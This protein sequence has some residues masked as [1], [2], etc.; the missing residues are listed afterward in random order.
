MCGLS[1]GEG[2]SEAALGFLERSCL[3]QRLLMAHSCAARCRWGCLGSPAMQHAQLAQMVGRP[4]GVVVYRSCSCGYR[5]RPEAQGHVD[6]IG[7]PVWDE[8]MRRHLE[9]CGVLLR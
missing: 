4:G 6:F 8:R 2:G 5:P 9:R 3:R 7:S 1:L